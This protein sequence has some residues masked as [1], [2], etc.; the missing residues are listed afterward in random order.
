MR[1]TT[2]LL[3]GFLFCLYGWV[4]TAI[5]ARYLEKVLDEV[6]RRLKEIINS[7]DQDG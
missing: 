6:S 7:S 4:R 2:L 5:K 1:L 3:F